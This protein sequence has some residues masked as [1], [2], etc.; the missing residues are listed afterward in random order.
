MPT[1]QPGGPSPIGTGFAVLSATPRRNRRGWST[2]THWLAWTGT[3]FKA[4]QSR[5][6]RRID[7]DTAWLRAAHRRD[8]ARCRGGVRGGDV[9]ECESGPIL[10]AGPPK[11]PERTSA[12]HQVATADRGSHSTAHVGGM[13]GG[14]MSS[15]SGSPRRPAGKG[16]RRRTG[17]EPMVVVWWPHP[18]PREKLDDYYRRS[19]Y[20]PF[21]LERRS[22][23]GRRHG[24]L[25]QVSNRALNEQSAPYSA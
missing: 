1:A 19:L 2:W 7:S 18:K 16:S 4:E 14:F 20:A 23:T 15:R 11:L 13:V 5:V 17:A 10:R 24:S 3:A 12:A 22:R 21:P 8:D 25:V 9:C 6:V